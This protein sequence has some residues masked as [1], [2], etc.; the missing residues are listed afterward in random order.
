[1][2]TSIQIPLDFKFRDKISM[3][4]FYAGQNKNILSH[5]H[6]LSDSSINTNSGDRFLFFWGESGCGKSHL[7][8]AFCK[9]MHE[10][11]KSVSYFSCTQ[12]A[13]IQPDMLEGLDKCGLIAIDDI[14][15]IAGDEKWELALFTYIRKWHESSGLLLL[16][17]NCKPADIPFKLQD[18]KTRIS[19]WPV[20]YQL[21][22]L[23][24][25]DKLKVL[26]DYAKTRGL[27]LGQE[28]GQ[29]ILTRFPR[30]LKSML[31]LLEKVD[32]AAM[33]QQRRLTIPFIKTL[34]KFD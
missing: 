25:T 33:S 3:S 1:M 10:S 21:H 9:Q 32:V 19:G 16:S 5:L 13:E 34:A 6:Q 23:P 30:N 14:N 28:V 29:F 15:V 7:L 4:R 12:V 18:L 24:D 27:E 20:V 31:E 26:Q 11:G 17:S 2:T 8:Q 22:A